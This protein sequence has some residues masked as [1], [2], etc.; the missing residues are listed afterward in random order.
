MVS[1]KARLI[2]AV[3]NDRLY[4]VVEMAEPAGFESLD[5]VFAKML[6]SFQWMK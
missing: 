1:D 5:E 2:V 3:R 4:S 6:E